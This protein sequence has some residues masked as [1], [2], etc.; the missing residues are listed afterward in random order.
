ME[1]KK[2]KIPATMLCYGTF[3]ELHL[4]CWIE[5]GL[6]ELGVVGR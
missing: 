6:G 5:A 3:F 2:G 4:C 1:R